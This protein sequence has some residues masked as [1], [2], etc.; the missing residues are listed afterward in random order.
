MSDF[1]VQ[2]GA[3]CF[4]WLCFWVALTLTSLAHS[5]ATARSQRSDSL[6]RDSEAADWERKALSVGAE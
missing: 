4:A 5:G 6:T 1:G 3:G 2:M